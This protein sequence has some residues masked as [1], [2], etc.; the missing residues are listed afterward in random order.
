MNGIFDSVLG[1]I[2]PGA[3]QQVDFAHLARKGTRLFG[4]MF[5]GGR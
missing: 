1:A 4:T 3:M 5:G 2:P